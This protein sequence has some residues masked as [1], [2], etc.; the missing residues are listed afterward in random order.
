MARN[1]GEHP[2]DPGADKLDPYR[3]K[4]RADRTPEPV[5]PGPMPAEPMRPGPTGPGTDTGP[6][7]TDDVPDGHRFVV[8]EH[9]A[10]AL[11]WDFRLERD[12]VLVSWALPK[13]L[14]L[15]PKTNHL[16]IHTEDHPLEYL[17]F[18]GDIPAGEYGGG[19]VFPWDRGTYDTE[20]W[21]ADEVKVVLHGERVS[22]RYVVFRTARASSRTRDGGAGGGGGRGAGFGG[23]RNWM[24]H[25]MDPAPEGWR[26]A[27]E[28]IRPMLAT[29]GSLPSPA[30]STQWAF[31]MK[32]DGVRAVV[33]VDGGRARVMNRNDRDVTRTFPE[34]G[35]LAESLGSRQVVLDGEVVALDRNG[36]P[37]F[38]LLQQR[39]HLENAN[40][41]RELAKRVPV[42]YLA[43]DLLYLDGR[44]LLDSPYDERRRQLESLGL[45]GPRWAVPPAFPGDGAAATETSRAQQLEGVVAKR[46]DSRYQPGRRSHSWV[47]VKTL[48][49]QEVVI[50]GWRPGS[51]R[52]TGTIGSLLIG[53]PDG[54]GLAYAGHVGTGFSDAALEHL[55]GLLKPLVRSSSA[56]T[57]EVPRQDARDAVWVEPTLVGE[58][59]FGEWTRDGRL[60]HPT[61][62]GLRPDKQPRDV[63]REA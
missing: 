45:E 57:G 34:I 60:R 48:R 11:H 10:T 37:D 28:L 7:V 53:L 42:T 27:P 14:P 20:K 63:V 29:A 18:A 38:G 47:K 17:T 3:S 31:E 50:G 61:W 19:S 24:I 4:R 55:A 40:Q 62:R 12:G 33:Y 9:H 56:F 32:W 51:G 21:S 30:D 2:A 44:T 23:D 58:V 1:D 6:A 41:I 35:D 8:T 36:R 59:A 39:M 46:R 15:D 54:N 43:F 13:G 5:P 16:A 22:G 25:R 49:T 52:R 26:A